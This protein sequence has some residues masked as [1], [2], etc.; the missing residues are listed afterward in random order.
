MPPMNAQDPYV[1]ASSQDPEAKPL[2]PGDA[3]ARAGAFAQA[4]VYGL[5]SAVVMWSL[6]YFARLLAVEGAPEWAQPSAPALFVVFLGVFLC[7]GG[8]SLF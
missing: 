7:L 8:V 1:A 5:G 6:G 4:L 2:E 3:P